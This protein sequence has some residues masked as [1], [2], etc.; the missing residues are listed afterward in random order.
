MCSTPFGPQAHWQN[1]GHFLPPIYSHPNEPSALAWRNFGGP[2]EAASQVEYHHYYGLN[3]LFLS[4]PYWYY[5][6]QHGQPSVA[7][8]RHVPARRQPQSNGAWPEGATLRGELRW[9]KLQRAYGPRRDLPNFVREDLRRVYGTYPRTDVSITYQGGEY[10]VR[11]DPQV[12][13]QEY[14]V[15]K[16]VVRRMESAEG[17]SVIEIVER[18]KKKKKKG[19]R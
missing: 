5:Q 4:N 15:E 18:K 2:H 16:K 14:R 13:S 19:T 11:G 1:T 7:S 6:W 10:V 3:P 8:L 17:D 12:G 9:G